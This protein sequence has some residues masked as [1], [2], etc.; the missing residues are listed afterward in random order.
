[1]PTFQR[2]HYVCNPGQ[3]QSGVAC[4]HLLPLHAAGHN[5]N[6]AVEKALEQKISLLTACFA[7]PWYTVDRSIVLQ[8]IVGRM[9]DLAVSTG[10]WTTV[11]SAPLL[12]VWTISMAFMLAI[13]IRNW[14]TASMTIAYSVA[15][16]DPRVAQVTCAL[17]LVP[18]T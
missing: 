3:N 1:M 12:L 18:I 6:S 4:H 14:T 16:P 5:A 9:D 15:F 10:N 11:H 2:S 8:E 13:T 17:K 7:K